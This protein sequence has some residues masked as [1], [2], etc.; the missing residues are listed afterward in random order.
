MTELVER[1]RAYVRQAHPTGHVCA[2]ADIER[3]AAEIE[4]LVARVGELEDAISAFLA[5][6]E[7]VAPHINDAFLMRELKCGPYTGPHY[8]E[9]LDRL[10]ALSSEGREG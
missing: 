6:H 2:C 8:G 1:L 3:A 5:K 4:R 7:Q 10:R 9:E